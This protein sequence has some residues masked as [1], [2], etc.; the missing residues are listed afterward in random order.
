M[1]I[2]RKKMCLIA[3]DIRSSREVLCSWLSELGYECILVADGIDAWREANQR[4][5]DLIITDIEMP[6]ASGLDLLH[7]LR[8]ETNSRLYA[9]PVI[10]ISSLIDTELRPLI[11]QLGSSFFM[12]KP[13]SKV[14]TEM[15]V[16]RVELHP[17]LSCENANTKADVAADQTSTEQVVSPRFRIL[18]SQ[19]GHPDSPLQ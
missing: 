4:R 15:A 17:G 1:N 12:E 5:F 9:I 8:R 19:V 6:Q 18:R 2:P 16:K 13:L 10:V 11:A 14:V 3:D 7:A